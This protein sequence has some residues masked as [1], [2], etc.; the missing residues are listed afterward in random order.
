MTFGTEEDEGGFLLF[1]FAKIA[2]EFSGEGEFLED[3]CELAKGPFIGF[4]YTAKNFFLGHDFLG[5]LRIYLMFF[6]LDL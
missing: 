4:V 5:F 6:P 3:F 2:E 1:E